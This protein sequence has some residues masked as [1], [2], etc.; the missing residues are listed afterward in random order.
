VTWTLQDQLKQTNSPPLQGRGKGWGLSAGK[1]DQLQERAR[2]MR[3]QP[4]EP[5]M[6]LW[7][8]ISGR[9]I[10]GYKFRR[11]AVIGLAIADFLC[12]EKGLIIEVDGITHDDPAADA[13]RTSRLEAYGFHVVRVTNEEVMR[14]IDGVCDLL[15][16]TLE[17]LPARRPPHPNPSP[18]EE[19][20]KGALKLLGISLEGSG[21]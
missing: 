6:R 21:A 8:A 5:E 16:H 3:N 11:Q 18:E 1:L 14:N 19:G 7:R 13:Q 17:T 4:T 15:L 20:L 10:G 12:P 9:K 2:H